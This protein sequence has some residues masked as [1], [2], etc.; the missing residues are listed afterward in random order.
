MAALILAGGLS[1]LSPANRLSVESLWLDAAN[2]PSGAGLFL[3]VQP[4]LYQQRGLVVR[5]DITVF[6]EC[7]LGK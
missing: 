6:V 3:E 5:G 4:C 1:D 7:Y 2:E